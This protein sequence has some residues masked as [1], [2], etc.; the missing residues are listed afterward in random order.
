MKNHEI[1]NWKIQSTKW[2]LSQSSYNCF[3]QS[4]TNEKITDKKSTAEKYNSL[5]VNINRNLAA[6]LPH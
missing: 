2:L 3:S 5:F 4:I 1:Y 6:K